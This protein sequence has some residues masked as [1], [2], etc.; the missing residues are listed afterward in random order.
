MNE[1]YISPNFSSKQSKPHPAFQTF[2]CKY[3]MYQN[4]VYQKP[5]IMKDILQHQL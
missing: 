5:G 2:N 1:L 3:L 4:P